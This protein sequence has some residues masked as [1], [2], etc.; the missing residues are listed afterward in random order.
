MPSLS[1]SARWVCWFNAWLA[2][3][4]PLETAVDAVRADD[5]AHHVLGTAAPGAE[6]LPPEPLL[7][8]WGG[9]RR[10]GASGASL[11]LPEPGDPYGL[12]GPAVFTAAATDSG[13][14]VVVDG[15][16]LGLIPEV[17]GS[18]VFW[19]RYEANPAPHTAGLAEASREL[20]TELAVTA[21]ELLTL[22]LARWQPEVRE[23]LSGIRDATDALL[24]PGYAPRA[25]ELAATAQR[26]LAIAE[27]AAGTDSAA[28]TAW[29]V[30]ARGNH[31]RGLARTARHALVAACNAG[32]PR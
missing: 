31:L 12:A 6:V 32:R 8:A 23:A 27:L 11:T 17:V 1:R 30:E 19:H 21:D 16:G 25:E 13:E 26:C 14:A 24:A 9:L 20:R 7:L 22:D 3:A 28:V 4:A 5:A 29:E 18:G 15:L 2:G 10:A